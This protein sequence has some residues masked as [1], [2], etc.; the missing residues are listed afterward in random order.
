L[1]RNNGDGTFTNIA[2][3]MGVA[4]SGFVKG[5]AWGDI[6]N[7]GYPELYVSRL[8]SPNALWKNERGRRFRN[9]T[10]AAGVGEPLH[11]FATWFWD[12]DNDGWLDLFV[13][14]FRTAM[15]GDIAAVHLGLPHGA[16][17]PRLYRNKRDGTFEDVTAAVRLNRTVL[18]MGANFGDLDNDGFLDCYLGTGEPDLRALLPNRMFRNAGGRV[19][20]DVT[21]A[22]GFGHLQK[23]HAVS[24]GDVDNDGDQDIYQ[25][26]GGAYEGD[27][28]RNVLYRNPGHG[29]DWVT[30]RLEGMKS[31]RAA[32]GARIKAVVNRPGGVGEIHGLVSAG[33]SFG[34]SSLQAELGL[35]KISTIQRI[36]VEWPSGLRQAFE[37]IAKNRRY[38]VREGQPEVR[39]W[40]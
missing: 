26:M 35:G 21:T 6:D 15:L 36:E 10:E 30:M 5:A 1:Y 3:P 37:G 13:A 22:G 34:A 39:P 8:G 32:I 40:P 24:F 29:N 16:E 14:P 38:I 11:S 4:D 17:L 18:V 27:S 2:N 23:G 20:Q 19:F 9:V 28:F 7:D 31:N 33:G 25:V 12:Y